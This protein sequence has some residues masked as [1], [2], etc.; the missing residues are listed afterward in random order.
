VDPHS[1]LE[2][3]DRD[4]TGRE[5][6]F[7]RSVAERAK[8]RRKTANSPQAFCFSRGVYEKVLA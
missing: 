5:S 8:F 4:S 1:G 7:A 2:Q 6:M 3:D